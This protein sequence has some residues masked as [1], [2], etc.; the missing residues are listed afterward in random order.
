[1]AGLYHLVRLND[2]WFM[3]DEPL[4][5]AFLERWCLET[6]I[7]HMSFGEYTITL[8]D[9]AYKLGLPI[10]NDYVSG[11]LTNFERYIEGGRPV[12]T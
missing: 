8:Q 5:S 7:F 1:M 2:H 9:V 12:W 3:L 11:C 10:D 4:V 6:H